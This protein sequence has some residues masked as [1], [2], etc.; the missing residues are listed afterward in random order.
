[1][2]K[3]IYVGKRTFKRLM[4]IQT[5]AAIILMGFSLT[6]RAVGRTDICR[7]MLENGLAGETANKVIR[8]CDGQMWIATS[9]GVCVF[10]GERTTRVDIVS[11]DKGLRNNQNVYDIC[12]AKSDHSIYIH[13]RR[14]ILP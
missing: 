3:D 2:D 1:M 11:S 7:L 12:E 13:S 14:N 8:D 9:N 4:A 5:A 6:V 10:N